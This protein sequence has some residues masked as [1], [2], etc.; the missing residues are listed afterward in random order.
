MAIVTRTGNSQQSLSLVR[1]RVP[2][3]CQGW[4]FSKFPPLVN[5]VFLEQ[6]V[7]NRNTLF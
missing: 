6:D 4:T 2:S 5:N 7:L 1:L 3:K